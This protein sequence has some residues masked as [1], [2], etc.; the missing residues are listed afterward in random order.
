[1]YYLTSLLLP[2]NFFI[3]LTAPP[4]I[5]YS[6]QENS[7]VQLELST[8]VT[9]VNC[10]C[11]DDVSF[12]SNQS[13]EFKGNPEVMQFTN[14]SLKLEVKKINCRSKNITNDLRETLLA[15]KY[16]NIEFELLSSNS[17][18]TTS[19][20]NLNIP[21]YLE[22]KTILTI[23]GK[24]RPQ[25][26]KTTVIKTGQ[27]TYRINATHTISLKEFGI[28]PKSPLKI[29]KIHDNALVTIDLLIKVK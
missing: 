23:A 20:K 18:H 28:V 15:D 10:K 27:D 4:R 8:N 9:K 12:A 5:N 7:K 19:S 25:T 6:L 1:M 3:L 24:K 21:N 14:T 22:A 11:L 17:F 16:P 2:I 13:A 26:I 29:V